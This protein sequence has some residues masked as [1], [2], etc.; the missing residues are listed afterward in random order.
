MLW[1]D[2]VKQKYAT[3][4]LWI[5]K[6]ITYPAEVIHIIFNGLINSPAQLYCATWCSC[7]PSGLHSE[8]EAGR[9]ASRNGWAEVWRKTPSHQ[10]FDG[11]PLAQHHGCPLCIDLIEPCRWRDADGTARGF[12]HFLVIHRGQ[13]HHQPALSSPLISLFTFADPGSLQMS[14]S[15][16]SSWIIMN[17]I[18][19]DDMFHGNC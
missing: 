9:K 4:M 7:S 6:T 1:F 18:T 16:S 19:L 11:R 12:V 15:F 5:S 2:K 17:Q 3:L 10:H 14:D 8:Q 13:N